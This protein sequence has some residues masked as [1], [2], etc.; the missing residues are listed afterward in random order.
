M[1][2]RNSFTF[3]KHSLVGYWPTAR[4]LSSSLFSA[5][6][7]FFILL[8][9]PIR[10]RLFG[11]RPKKIVLFLGG[12]RI[13][14]FIR[15]GTDISALREIFVGEEYIFNELPPV[16]PRHIADM[17]AHIGTSVL[18]FHFLYPDARITAYEPDPENFQLLQMNVGSLLQVKCVNVAVADVA[19]VITFYP[20][21]GGSTRASVKRQEDSREGIQVACIGVDEVI[22]QGID[23]IKFDVEGAEYLM[24][25]AATK[26]VERYV[27]EV[28][29]KLIGKTREQFE[30]L[31]PEFSFLWKSRGADHSIVA[32]YK[33]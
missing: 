5:G 30:T 14:F 28:H 27:G 29:H 11:R 12:T 21:E 18:F 9:I 23:F 20:N 8:S 31:F 10:K 24:F 7:L 25:A 2:I 1:N 4:K 16:T 17:G 26:K 19:G 3:Y 32:I 15:D 6:V 22:N 13:P 33:P